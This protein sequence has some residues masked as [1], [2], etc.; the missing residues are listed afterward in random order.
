M[1]IISAYSFAY[2]DLDVSNAQYLADQ[3]LITKQSSEAKFRLDDTITRAEVV[4]MALKIQW[5]TLPENYTCKNYF[6][7]VKYDAK[8]NWICRAVELAADAELVSRSNAKFRPQDNISRA[9]ALAILTPDA[10]TE[11]LSYT[12]NEWNQWQKETLYKYLYYT[13]TYVKF[14][15]QSPLEDGTKIYPDYSNFTNWWVAYIQWSPDKAATRA[16]VFWFA[17]NIISKSTNSDQEYEAFTADFD[18]QNVHRSTYEQNIIY[19][20]GEGWEFEGSYAQEFSIF[21]EPIDSVLYFD[22]GEKIE[23]KDW[24]GYTYYASMSWWMCYSGKLVFIWEN[25]IITA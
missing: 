24:A 19:A 9:E 5:K 17:R 15:T 23:K 18:G 16:E 22:S 13:E 7:D 10:T 2:T 8:N 11:N 3:K 21:I 1:A 20:F 12:T 4:G 25:N 6:S 14:Y